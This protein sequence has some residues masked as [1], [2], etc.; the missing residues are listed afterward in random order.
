M[1]NAICVLSVKNYK[2][3]IV[4]IFCETWSFSSFL[5]YRSKLTHQS[6]FKEE[7]RRTLQWIHTRDWS[8]H[9]L[10]IRSAYH[11]EN[12]YLLREVSHWQKA[13]IDFLRRGESAESRTFLFSVAD[14][15]SVPCGS[16]L[17]RC[18]LYNTAF[19]NHFKFWQTRLFLAELP[20]SWNL[21]IKDIAY[22][23]RRAV[24]EIPL[25]DAA[26]FCATRDHYALSFSFTSSLK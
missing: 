12:E 26:R 20:R 15:R 23:R 2:I 22:F 5:C 14:S 9:S 17:P 25:C 19:W 4:S 3:A 7:E 6:Y 24:R 16:E 21:G 1:S 13:R 18:V 11:S 10:D 8:C